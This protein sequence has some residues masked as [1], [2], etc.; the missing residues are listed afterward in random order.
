MMPGDPKRVKPLM[1]IIQVDENYK[2]NTS[3]VNIAVKA[4]VKFDLRR[5]KRKDG[6]LCEV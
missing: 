6:T 3:E 1:A 5:G 2:Y 4:N